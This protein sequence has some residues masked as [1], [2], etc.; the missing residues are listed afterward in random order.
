MEDESLIIDKF[1]LILL[2]RV[3]YLID[4]VGSFFLRCFMFERLSKSLSVVLILIVFWFFLD[5]SDFKNFLRDIYFL[6]ISGL[7]NVLWLK[8]KGMV[9]FFLLVYLRK[10][11]FLKK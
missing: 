4:L 10:L 6:F 3:L 9:L 1:I 7:E 8:M 2:F 11:F 5:L